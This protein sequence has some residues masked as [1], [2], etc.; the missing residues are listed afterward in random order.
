MR[1][2]R[3]S[4]MTPQKPSDSL[5]NYPADKARQGEIILKTPLQR[6]IFVGGLA[7]MLLLGLIATFMGR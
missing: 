3:R 6:I 7:G 4:A 1:P 2:L 5:R